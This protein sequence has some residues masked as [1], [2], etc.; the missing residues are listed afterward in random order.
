MLPEK[1]H[2]H[3]FGYEEF[4]YVSENVDEI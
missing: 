3:P 1:A 4:N 2:P